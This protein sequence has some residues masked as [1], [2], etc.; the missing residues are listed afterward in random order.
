M[1]YEGKEQAPGCSPSVRV[2]TKREPMMAGKREAQRRPGS[3]GGAGVAAPAF[4]AC[5]AIKR[6]EKGNPLM[7]KPHV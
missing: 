1:W 2:L 4:V 7:S 3:T 5:C 6:G